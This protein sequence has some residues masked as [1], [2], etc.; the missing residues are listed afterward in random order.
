VT[1][2]GSTVPFT[3]S[4]T[5]GSNLPFILF[6]GQ[7]YTVQ[8]TAAYGNIH[9]LHWKDNNNANLS[10]QVTLSGNASYT[11]IYVVA[12]G[13][14]T[15]TSQKSSSSTSVTTTSSTISSTTRATSSSSTSGAPEFPLGPSMVLALVLTAVLFLLSQWKPGP[16]RLNAHRARGTVSSSG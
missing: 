4:F 15:T 16:P 7:T 12:T 2:P 13:T 3:G 11:A 8:M 14:T 9:F 10:R 1:P 6:K 5:G